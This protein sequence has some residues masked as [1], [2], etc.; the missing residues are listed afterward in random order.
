MGGDIKAGAAYVELMLRDMKFLKGLK[1]AGARLAKFAK[2]AAA[3]GAAMAAAAAGGVAVAVKQFTAMGSE[4]HRM[5]TRIGTSVESLSALEHAAKKTGTPVDRLH[6]GLAELTQRLGE[7][8][9]TGSGSAAEQLERLG[10]SA[11]ELQKLAPEAALG[12]IADAVNALPNKSDQLFA[13]D[14]LMGGDSR[15]LLGL[16]SQ[17]SAGIAALTSEAKDLGL[18]MSG[19]AAAGAARLQEAFSTVVSQIKM[20]VFEIGGAFAPVIE[21]VIP[22]IQ[23]FATTVITYIRSAGSVV[24]ST[25]NTVY[26]A[27]APVVGAYLTT[28]TDVFM[29][30]WDIT[31]EVFTS[32]G[33]IV[34]SVWTNITG[35]TGG[36]MQWLQ[37]SIIGGLSV[38]SFSFKNWK[39][40]L[41]RTIVGVELG[42]VRFA[43]QVKYF[44][45]EVIPSV[46]SWLWENWY[47]IWKTIGDWVGTVASNIWKNLQNLWKSIQ[48]LFSGEGWTFEWTNLTEGFESSIKKLP[49]I[50]ERELG[51]LERRL[52]KEVDDIG[53][54]INKK[55]AEHQKEFAATSKAWVPDDLLVGGKVGGKAAAQVNSF[56]EGGN[57]AA[58]NLQSAKNE[59]FSTFSAAA[60]A[61]Q[62]RGGKNEVVD[63]LDK[64]QQENKKLLENIEKAINRQEGLL[65][66]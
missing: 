33:N 51:P 40:L 47:D 45:G 29:G 10:L 24:T 61:A 30:I 65:L 7:A 59:I 34:N 52:A 27:T 8:S 48:G 20:I 46:L 22:K 39:L 62:G 56:M 4:V 55:W 53:T 66:A 6:E 50:A 14:E 18:V 12:K 64:V 44:F 17:G 15:E 28:I 1:A 2:V 31:K 43:N 32:I 26:Q 11:K 57:P 3:A 13:F 23:Q 49:E 63:K 36:F 58:A 41:T 5:A 21:A 54:E 16:L 42:V 38:I 19:D 25:W 35:S 37:E 9:A 60:A